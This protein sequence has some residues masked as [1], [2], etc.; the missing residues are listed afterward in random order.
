[1]RDTERSSST[2]YLS[3]PQ[4]IP[5]FLLPLLARGPLVLEVHVTLHS[6]S[7]TEAFLFRSEWLGPGAGTTHG[8]PGAASFVIR[9]GDVCLRTSRCARRCGFLEKLPVLGWRLRFRSLEGSRFC[10]RF[11]RIPRARLPVGMAGCCRAPNYQTSSFSPLG[12]RRETRG[13]RVLYRGASHHRINGIL[14]VPGNGLALSAHAALSDASMEIA[15]SPR[16]GLL[17]LT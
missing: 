7:L 16:N 11:L 2:T 10:R 8:R 13:S 15:A 3:P 9:L 1:M 6:Q 5:Y 14:L 17:V 4:G 12:I